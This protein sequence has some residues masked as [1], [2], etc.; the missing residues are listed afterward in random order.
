MALDK[1][2]V[3]DDVSGLADKP[4][5]FAYFLTVSRKFGITCVYVFH[6]IYPTRQNWQMMLSQ[7]KLINIFLVQ[8]KL[9]L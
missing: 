5:A 2:N 6:A 7:T 9:P 4:E 8:C 3:M 1:L